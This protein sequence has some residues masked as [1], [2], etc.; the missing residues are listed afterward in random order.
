M[1]IGKIKGSVETTSVFRAYMLVLRG[2]YRIYCRWLSPR[3]HYFGL[4]FYERRYTL[5]PIEAIGES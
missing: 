2:K 1:S 4:T 3:I 5:L